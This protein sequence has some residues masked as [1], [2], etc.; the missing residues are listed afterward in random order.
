ML[1][2]KAAD[3]SSSLSP[4]SEAYSNLPTPEPSNV[5]T[6]IEHSLDQSEIESPYW[7]PLLPIENFYQAAEALLDVK[8]FDEARE[9]LRKELVRER[10]E[11]FKREAAEREV[12]KAKGP[13]MLNA[14][15]G[16]EM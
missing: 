6:E 2:E 14:D 8:E 13:M 9:A 3:E 15:L 10:K 11:K 1:A 16:L 7:P 5:E 4:S 12:L